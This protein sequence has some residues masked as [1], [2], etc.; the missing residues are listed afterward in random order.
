[1]PA[2]ELLLGNDDPRASAAELFRRALA[3]LPEQVMRGPG[4]VA[5]RTRSVT[6]AN[7]LTTPSTGLE[8]MLTHCPAGTRGP[9]LN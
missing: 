7:R 1:V 3:V 5:G 8:Q 4:A 2:A 6:L 9:A